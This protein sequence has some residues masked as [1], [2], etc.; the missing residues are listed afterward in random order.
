MESIG[1]FIL[2]NNILNAKYMLC[3]IIY[4]TKTNICY[5]VFI[6]K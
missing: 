6:I 4:Y 5:L 2:L 3:I 1:L